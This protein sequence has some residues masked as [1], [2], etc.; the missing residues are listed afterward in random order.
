MRSMKSKSYTLFLFIVSSVIATAQ[1]SELDDIRRRNAEWKNSDDL[2]RSREEDRYKKQLDDLEQG[3][4]EFNQRENDLRQQEL[5]RRMRSAEL[6]LQRQQH[7][8]DKNSVG[9]VEF[10][11]RS[12]VSDRVLAAKERELIANM[13]A[14]RNAQKSR[15]LNEEEMGILARYLNYEESEADRRKR[16]EKYSRNLNPEYLA[17][18]EN[19]TALHKSWITPHLPELKEIYALE[20]KNRHQQKINETIEGAYKI[21]LDVTREISRVESIRGGRLLTAAEVNSV[22]R[23]VL[24]L[25]QNIKYIREMDFPPDQESSKQKI[26]SVFQNHVSDLK[27]VFQSEKELWRKAGKTSAK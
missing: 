5:E 13:D 23:W 11:S 17:T 4:R 24:R 27:Y 12:S 18:L 25:N 9:R 15:L 1:Q 6:E 10:G 22:N 26:L 7:E 8:P 21:D 19:E 16:I 3:Q 2:R 20:V 14:L